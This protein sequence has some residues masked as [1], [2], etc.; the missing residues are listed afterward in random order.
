MR[1]VLKKSMT[2]I[3]ITHGFSDITELLCIIK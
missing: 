3:K 1:D 2:G